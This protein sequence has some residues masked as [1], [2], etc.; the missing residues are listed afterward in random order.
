MSGPII[1]IR[2]EPGLG[3]TVDAAREMGMEVAA[4]PLFAVRPLEWDAPDPADYDALLIGSANA[5]RHGGAA[6]RAMRGK[7]VH[8]VG[9]ATAEAARRA[10]FTVAEIGSG[11]LQGLLDQRAGP[12]IRFLRLAG[13][14]RVALA[15]PPTVT[16]LTRTVYAS[17]P[18]PLPNAMAALLREGA[19][20]L[21]HSAA[22]SRHFARECARLSVPR[23]SIRLA[24]LAPRVA[25]AAGNGWAEVRT[26]QTPREGSLLALVRDMCHQ[27]PPAPDQA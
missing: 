21:L 22:A 19:I 11:G 1:A 7:P 4:F 5:I 9:E 25:S 18:L 12:P 15:P 14:E 26:A 6:T 24:A 17:E 27:P 10:G 23:G 13:A 2:P 16:I 20:V 3:G 8:A